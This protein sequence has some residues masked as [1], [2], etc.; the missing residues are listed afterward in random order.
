MCK[1]VRAQLNVDRMKIKAQGGKDITWLMQRLLPLVEKDNIGGLQLL[2]MSAKDLTPHED[3]HQYDIYDGQEF[4]DDASGKILDKKMAT[5]ARRAEMKFFRD[6]GVYSKVMRSEAKGPIITTRWL[7]VNK[8]A[9]MIP[10]YRS[11]L[12]ARDVR[13]PVGEAGPRLESCQE[14]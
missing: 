6:R 8:G 7:D 5:A 2:S 9:T 1:G 12:V 13:V 4:Y 11:M 14:S 3:E 10:N